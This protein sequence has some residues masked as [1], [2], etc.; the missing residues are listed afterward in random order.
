LVEHDA[1]VAVAEH[2]PAPVVVAVL[3]IEAEFFV[4]RDARAQVFDGEHG[5][6]VHGIG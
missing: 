2:R 5:D 1:A 3:D 6:E 4:E